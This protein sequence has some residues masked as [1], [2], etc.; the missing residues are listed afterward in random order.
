MLTLQV[1]EWRDKVGSKTTAMP[2]I[3]SG[4]V[5][6]SGSCSLQT[7][8]Q[9]LDMHRLWQCFLKCGQRDIIALPVCP[10]VR[11]G[12]V[13]IFKTKKKSVTLLYIVQSTVKILRSAC[14]DFV[15][16]AKALC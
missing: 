14:R 10:V 13:S 16:P 9:R 4:K 15:M 1:G 6:E 3:Q 12:T 5:R 11:S 7:E 8:T 2:L